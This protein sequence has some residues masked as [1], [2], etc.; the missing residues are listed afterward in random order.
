MSQII[1][2]KR[3]GG[4]DSP[5]SLAAGELAIN[6]DSGKLFYGS[7]SSVL[8]SYT[9]TNISASG[10]ISSSAHIYGDRYYSDSQLALNHVNSAITLGYHNTYPINIGKSTNPTKIY[11]HLTASLISASGTISANGGTFTDDIELG[12]MK[13]LKGARLSISASS[14]TQIYGDTTFH[15]D[16]TFSGDITS[17]LRI[18]GSGNTSNNWITIDA[19]NGGDTSGGGICFY[20]TGTDTIGAPQYGAKIVYNEDDDEFAIGTMDNNTFKR[21]IWMKRNLDYV[22]LADA[23]FSEGTT[24]G[25]ILSNTNTTVAD[26]DS[27]GNLAWKNS[28]D[29]STT[30][31]IKGIATEDHADDAN[32][33]SKIEFQVTPNGTSALVT[34]VTIDQDKNLVA[35]RKFTKTGNTDGTAEGDIVYMGGTTSMTTGAIYHFKSDGTWELADADAAST[36]DGLLGVALGAASDTNGVLLRGMVTLDH[37]PGAVGDVLYLSTTA[38]DCSA[39]APSG[40]GDIVR[41]IGYCLDASNGQIWFNPDNTFVEVNA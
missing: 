37:D 23:V 11:G 6:L 33:G 8:S 5:S 30:L 38:G 35:N 15:Q 29:T 14:N 25:F 12:D 40:N 18:G 21:Q 13:R 7:G 34:A 20:E 26:G 27:L 32:G 9:F 39:T 16:V 31:N 36:S 22:Y 17:N 1:Q 19:Q 4:S 2:I 41:V 24:P 28:D 10:D 3:G